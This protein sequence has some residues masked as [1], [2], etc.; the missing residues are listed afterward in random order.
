MPH[1]Y[2]DI[3]FKRTFDSL[4]TETKEFFRKQEERQNEN[5]F[6]SLAQHENYSKTKS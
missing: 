2:G 1:R 3:D 6:K 4:D 5:D